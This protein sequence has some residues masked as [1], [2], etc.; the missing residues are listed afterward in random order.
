MHAGYRIRDFRCIYGASVRLVMDV[1]EWDNCVCINAPGQSGDR[2]SPHYD[3]L[4]SIWA[5]GQYVPLLYSRARVE[6]AT[7]VRVR[8]VAPVS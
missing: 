3:D 7:V 4:A 6:E 2:G 5:R 1:G 8:L